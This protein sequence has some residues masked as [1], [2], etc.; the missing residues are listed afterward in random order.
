M[1]SGNDPELHEDAV[2][3]TVDQNIRSQINRISNTELFNSNPLYPRNA[4]Q[5][6]VEPIDLIH[7]VF[8]FAHEDWEKFHEF[9]EWFKDIVSTSP[10]G[11]QVKMEKYD[12]HVLPP[13]RD[14]NIRDVCERAIFIL[15]FLSHHYC[16][17]KYL[18]FFLTEGIGCTRLH[19]KCPSIAGNVSYVV[20]K[21]KKYAIR[22]VFTADPHSGAYRIPTGLT[23]IRGIDYHNN[24]MEYVKY[25]V[26]EMIKESVR[27]FNE[28]KDAMQR[29]LTGVD[30][31]E[32]LT[33][34]DRFVRNQEPLSTSDRDEADDNWSITGNEECTLNSPNQDSGIPA[35]EGRDFKET[36]QNN[37]SIE[38]ADTPPNHVSTVREATESSNQTDTDIQE[39]AHRTTQHSTSN[40]DKLFDIV[41]DNGPFHKD[42]AKIRSGAN[43]TDQVYKQFYNERIGKLHTL[44]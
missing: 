13:A 22:P 9:Y 43:A 40:L 20:E 23:M 30:R 12:S 15:P 38:G 33:G 39:G 7:F 8:V 29:A 17:N 16:T 1:N 2:P 42:Q 25:H 21:Q 32:M 28:R 44:P 36:L 11:D 41:T 4:D 14:D 31:F 18:T 10:Y 35:A 5:N 19:P 34:A 24:E 6:P 26:N 3:P 37:Q 27:N